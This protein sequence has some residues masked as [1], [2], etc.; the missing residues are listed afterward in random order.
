M[1]RDC[2]KPD[3]IDRHVIAAVVRFLNSAPGAVGDAMTALDFADMRLL[4]ADNVQRLYALNDDGG[5]AHCHVTFMPRALK[6]A[7]ITW[8]FDGHVAIVATS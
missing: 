6:P 7:T 5:D 1:L 2:S 8:E 4:Y 3:M